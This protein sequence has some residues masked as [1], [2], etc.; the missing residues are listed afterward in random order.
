[1]QLYDI[2]I[3]FSLDKIFD[4]SDNMDP[5]IYSSKPPFDRNRKGIRYQK[6]ES[7]EHQ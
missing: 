1:M 4:A 6:I 2:I 3:C 7:R 5:P